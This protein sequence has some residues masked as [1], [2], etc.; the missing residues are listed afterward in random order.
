MRPDVGTASPSTS[1][2]VPP[3]VQ[4]G[5]PR[6]RGALTSARATESRRRG[7]YVP[8]LLSTSSEMSH[9]LKPSN[10]FQGNVSEV[11]DTPGTWDSALSAPEFQE[12]TSDPN[13][14]QLDPEATGAVGLRMIWGRPILDFFILET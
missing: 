6:K 8:G 9:S 5:R 10:L 11:P 2:F 4:R 1:P 7:S 3:K 13:T 12:D 14:T